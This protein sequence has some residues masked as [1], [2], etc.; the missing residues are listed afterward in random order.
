MASFPTLTT[1]A[2]VLL[3]VQLAYRTPCRSL[4]FGDMSQ[5]R[6]VISA[7]LQKLTLQLDG[8]NLVDYVQVRDFFEAC[9]GAFDATWDL[10]ISGTTYSYLAFDTDEL[11][12]VENVD[13]QFTITLPVR[14]VRKN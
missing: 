4:Q 14:Q 7:T 2:A 8:L 6:F 5:Q 10:T 3:G 12:A 1:G 11:S 9:K 13:R